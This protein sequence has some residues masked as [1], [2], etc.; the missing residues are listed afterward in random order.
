MDMEQRN[1]SNRRIKKAIRN[2]IPE[3]HAIEDGNF[4]KEMRGKKS[5][6]SKLL[7][8]RKKAGKKKHG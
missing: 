3:K 7:A 5:K 1:M 4:T 8:A 2:F 6:T